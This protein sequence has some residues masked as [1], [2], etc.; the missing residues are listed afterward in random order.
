M[1]QAQTVRIP[2]FNSLADDMEAAIESFLN[3]G[4]AKNLSPNTLIYYKHRLRAFRGFRTR[5]HPGDNHTRCYT[6]LPG[7]G[8]A[9]DKPIHG[10]PQLHSRES[11][12]RFS[13]A[14]RLHRGEPDQRG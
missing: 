3:Y 11:L 2:K 5:P 4:R 1:A 10:Q 8:N 14:G 7:A 12:F 6:G 13:H 9:E